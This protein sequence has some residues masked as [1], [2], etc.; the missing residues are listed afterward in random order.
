MYL[1]VGRADLS[2]MPRY[3][4]PREQG[5]DAASFHEP[6][7]QQPRRRERAARPR[8]YR[9]STSNARGGSESDDKVAADGQ[10][11]RR[12]RL[13]RSSSAA[14][15]S[16]CEPGQSQE[17]GGDL[18][19][20]PSMEHQQRASRTAGSD[21]T[22][23]AVA[24]V[25]AVATVAGSTV[26]VEHMQVPETPVPLRDSVDPE[27][28]AVS[29]YLTPASALELM[30][31]L[32]DCST[33]EALKLASGCVAY[34]LS[35]FERIVQCKEFLSLSFKRMEQII[36]DDE[37]NV[38]SEDVSCVQSRVSYAVRSRFS[39]SLTGAYPEMTR[40]AGRLRGG[41]VLGAP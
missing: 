17:P 9:T 7:L 32:E 40:R 39:S 6:E 25:P 26:Q 37:L 16:V 2:E 13:R 21:G 1:K 36:A 34:V 5:G 38:S 31:R 41:H 19:I 35:N 18:D 33:A 24:A 4:R 30:Q 10:T 8:V 27:I 11:S 23:E 20:P 14:S 12:K 15:K 3:G 29:V 28:A 22:D